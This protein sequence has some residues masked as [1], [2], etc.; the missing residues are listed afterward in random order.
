MGSRK[1]ISLWAGAVLILAVGLIHVIDAPDSFTEASYKGWLFCANG[2]GALVA[3]YGI[4]RKRAW[5]WSLGFVI[6]GISIIL[7][8]V[9]RSIG[10]PLLP[11]EPD[12]WFEP[13]GVASFIAE[14]LFVAV[15]IFNRRIH[16]N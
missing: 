9:S 11:A 14:G 3:A 7:Y 12:A 8:V 16:E 10:L 6:A 13:I 5:G 1:N 4:I 2:L 15:Y